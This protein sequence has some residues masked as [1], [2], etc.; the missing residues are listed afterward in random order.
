[1]ASTKPQSMFALSVAIA[2]GVGATITIGAGAP[3]HYEFN[4]SG[5]TK[6]YRVLVGGLVGV[7]D[8]D[9]DPIELVTELGVWLAG[10]CA[11]PKVIVAADGRITIKCDDWQTVTIVWDTQ[12]GIAVGEPTLTTDIP[13]AAAVPCAG[14]PA[15]CVLLVSTTEDRGWTT[16]LSHVATADASDGTVVAF[17]DQRQI[18]SRTMTWNYLPRDWAMRDASGDGTTPAWPL[19]SSGTNAWLQPETTAAPMTTTK[20]YTV[21]DFLTDAPGR[22]IAMMLSVFQ[23]QSRPAVSGY[24]WEVYVAS[25]SNTRAPRV[26]AIPGS[27]RYVNVGNV[28]LRMTGRLASGYP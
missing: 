4:A 18:V 16:E 21:H 25:G 2:D 8:T 13:A 11:A 14:T 20:R 10:I 3:T 5:S 6:W 17:T 9:R 23:A 26:V 28:T 22:P 7:G 1:M 24:A 19:E 12:L 15:G 27:T